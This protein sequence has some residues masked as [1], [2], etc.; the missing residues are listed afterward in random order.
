MLADSVFLV[1][2]CSCVLDFAFGPYWHSQSWSY[3]M[4]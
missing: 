3:V 4:S 1:T 2:S